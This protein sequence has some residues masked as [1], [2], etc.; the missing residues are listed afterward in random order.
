MPPGPPCFLTLANLPPPPATVIASTQDRLI[1]AGIAANPNRIVYSKLR[2]KGEVASF[3]DALYIDL[4]PDGGKITAIDFL[5]ETMIVFKQ[6][7]IYALPGD[8]FNNNGGGQNYGPS[9][10]LDSD[11]GAISA[12]GV[13][14]TPKGLL[15]KRSKGWFL[16][17]HGWQANYV[18][19]GVDAYDT[20]TI[21]A[22]HA[23]DSQHQVRCVSSSRTLIWDYLIGEWIAWTTTAVDATMWGNVHHL[24]NSAAD[25][26]LAQAATYSGSGDLPGLDIETGWIKMGELQ[27]F[28][29]VR[30]ILILGEYLGAHDL[31]VRV[32]YNY[33]ETASGPT[34]VDD[35]TWTVS[36][37]TINGP[38]QVRH[39]PSR[40]K[41]EAIKIRITA[42]AIGATTHPVTQALN[43]TG[44]SLEV[45]LKQGAFANLPATQKQ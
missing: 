33:N 40:P 16:L 36:P 17:N 28:K 42:Q 8:G 27:G 24:V 12:E 20:D 5:N 4:P 18:G 11:V 15:F 41:C 35:K 2:G 1:L 30:N 34:W 31:R 3:S 10:L 38:L 39:G 23:M 13:V 45:A 9:R 25:G 44:L 32:A 29:L 19:R 43:L 7:A 22:C 21:V 26:V 6:S 37:T 14:L